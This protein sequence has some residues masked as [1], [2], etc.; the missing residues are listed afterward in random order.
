MGKGFSFP[1]KTSL[2]GLNVLTILSLSN[3][4]G[5]ILFNGFGDPTEKG[6]PFSNQDGHFSRKE[7]RSEERRD[8]TG[9]FFGNHEVIASSRYWEKREGSA[10]TR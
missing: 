1:A 6:N 2:C 10:G 3:I 9:L 4:I 7:G 8:R 5:L